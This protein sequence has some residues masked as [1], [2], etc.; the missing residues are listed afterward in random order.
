MLDGRYKVEPTDNI[1]ILLGKS[2]RD[3]KVW[4]DTADEF[5][6]DRM[7]DENFDKV[8]AEFPGCWKVSRI[9]I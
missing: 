3:T 9:S 7:L 5:D 2:Q 8:T 4:G 6:P 1:T